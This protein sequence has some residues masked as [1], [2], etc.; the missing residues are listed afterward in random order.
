MRR[1]N[2]QLQHAGLYLGT[3]LLPKATKSIA[4]EKSVH[5]NGDQ[6]VFLSLSAWI[7]TILFKI[8]LLNGVG[9]W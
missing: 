1:D 6:G 2:K 4:Y 5:R 8:Q 9:Q 7:I 3:L